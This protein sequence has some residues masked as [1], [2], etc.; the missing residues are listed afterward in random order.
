M[1]RFRMAIDTPPAVALAVWMT[2]STT[3]FLGCERDVSRS[4]FEAAAVLREANALAA[5]HRVAEALEYIE[6]HAPLAEVAV[7]GDDL[8]RLRIRQARLL[9]S[10]GR[11]REALRILEPLGKASPDDPLLTRLRGRAL[12]DAGD[13]AGAAAAIGELP[14]DVRLEERLAYGE[15]LLESG[16]PRAAATVLASRLI[17]S[18]HEDR[19]YLLFG[20]ALVKLDREDLARAFLERYREGEAARRDEREAT[21][22]EYDGEKAG[23]L[24]LRGRVRHRRGQWFEAMLLYNRAK[25]V[26][27]RRRGG[28]RR[29]GDAHLA[30]AQLSLDLGRPHDAIAALTELPPEA[31]VLELRGRAH[32]AIG[33]PRRAL[34]CYREALEKGGRETIPV[35]LEAA[36]RL[37]RGTPP[38]HDAPSSFH[39]DEAAIIERMDGRPLSRSIPELLALTGALEGRGAS[40]HARALALFAA[41]L[42]PSSREARLRVAALFGRPADVFVRLWAL[43]PLDDLEARRRFDAEV[44]SLGLSSEEL[45]AALRGQRLH[46]GADGG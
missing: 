44:A 7:S 46:R 23:A 5:R 13:P 21:R 24:L 1:R 2:S 42:A 41:R 11:P 12:L 9:L 20:R 28:G 19:G 4:S 45:S 14:P 18:P 33:E 43:R 8:R 37:E 17:D 34:S 22:R 39:G 38:P 26:H 30:L 35:A 3:S 29:L 40:D 6:R 32:E 15:A 10:L 27:E 36:R 31:P 25:L 16:R